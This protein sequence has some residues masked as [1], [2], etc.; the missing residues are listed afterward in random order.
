[1]EAGLHDGVGQRPR[2][3]TL[4]ADAWDRVVEEIAAATKRF[5]LRADAPVSSCYE[6]GR[7][8][9]WIHRYLTGLGVENPVVDSS[10][11]EVPRRARRA[12]TDRIDVNKPLAML[13]RA[14]IG[15][16]SELIEILE[17]IL[18]VGMAVAL[19]DDCCVQKRAVRQVRV[20]QRTLVFV[21]SLNVVFQL[22]HR[23]RSDD[24]SW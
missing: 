2:R 9:F 8:G 4:R 1:M 12:K 19:L 6:A 18:H 14:V 3:R 7:D 23:A 5:G 13:L 17:R 10:S 16:D 21:C 22:R 15:E 11:I 20:R 24:P